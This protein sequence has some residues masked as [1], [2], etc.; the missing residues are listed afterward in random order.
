MYSPWSQ[1]TASLLNHSAKSIECVKKKPMRSLSPSSIQ[2][3]T[4]PAHQ[5]LTK[6]KEDKRSEGDAH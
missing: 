6:E 3:K 1:P 5:I 4:L 2:A